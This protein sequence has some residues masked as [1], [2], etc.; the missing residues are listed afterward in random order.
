MTVN[1]SGTLPDQP[2]I[3]V[4]RHVSYADGPLLAAL[5]GKPCLF[6]V[7]PRFSGR[8]PW[9][10]LLRAYGRLAG[11][12]TMVPLSPDQPMSLKTL[13]RHMDRGGR[14]VIFPEGDISPDG[15][16]L[17]IQ[18][19]AAALWVRSGVDLVPIRYAG[20]EHWRF[21]APT[22]KHWLPRVDVEIGERIPAPATTQSAQEQIESVL[23]RL[24]IGLRNGQERVYIR[25]MN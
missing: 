11:G 22:G 3:I 9:R 12:H 13:L 7:S 25:A 10:S 1:I 18:P 4:C 17:P 8:E 6:A 20:A 14:V 23:Y 15:A 21:L 2:A 19:G 24:P 5:L 16:P